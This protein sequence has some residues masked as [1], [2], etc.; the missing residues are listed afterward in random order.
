MTEEELIEQLA[1][2][3]HASWAHW[4]R[5]VD[6]PYSKLFGQEKESDRVEAR[7]LLPI[8]GQYRSEQ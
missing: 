8:I 4:H 6:T 3:A 7:K 2:K 5:Q 1:D